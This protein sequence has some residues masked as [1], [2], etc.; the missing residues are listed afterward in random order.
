MS[1]FETLAARIESTDSVVSVGLDPDPSRLPDSVADADL[2]RWAF[3]RRIIDATHEHAACYKPNA[4]F[5]EDADGWRALRETIAYAHGRD[6]PVLLDAKRA[7][8]G[9]TTRRYAAALDDAD[10]IT[11]NPY[12]GRDSLQ[13]FL[14]RAEKGVFVLCRTSNPGGSDLQDLELASGEPLYERVAALADV[15]NANDNVGLVVG[16]TAPE[17]L[18]EV[19]EIVPE[20]PFLVPGVGAQGGDA[21]AAVEHG[22]AD[23]PDAAVDVGLVNSSRGIVF[24]GEESSRPDDEA[25]YFGA[26]GDAAKRLKKRL[27]RHR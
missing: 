9:N 8:I 21:E 15:W 24:A 12:L 6:V 25:T 18:A 13:P 7:D 20:I 22:L 23:R 10:A 14:D 11:V 4:A 17:E 27:N 19:R 2:P 5:Y 16:A 1:F 3:N 26:A